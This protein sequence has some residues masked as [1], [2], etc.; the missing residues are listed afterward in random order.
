MNKVQKG[1]VYVSTDA[2]RSARIRVL[3]LS[4]T[5]AL[6]ESKKPGE[7]R[8]SGYTRIQRARLCPK[9]HWK[10]VKRG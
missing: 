5:Y 10:L 6:C 7:R 8:Y 2:R 9:H 4:A 1:N 3:E